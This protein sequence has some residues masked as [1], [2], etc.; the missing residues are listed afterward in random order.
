MSDKTIQEQIKE[1][2]DKL[3]AIHATIATR[4]LMRHPLHK[5]AKVNE[6]QERLEFRLQQHELNLVK[7][8]VAIYEEVATILKP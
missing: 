8:K 7:E 5:T 2:Y 1:E 3:A 4:M 6:L